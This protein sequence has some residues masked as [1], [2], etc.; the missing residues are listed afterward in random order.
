[1]MTK[2]QL[3]GMRKE[4]IP[5]VS[6]AVDAADLPVLAEWLTEKDDTV[7][8]HAFLLLQSRSAATADVYPFWDRFSDMLK[9]ANS[10]HR[11]IGLMLVAENAKWDELNKTDAVISDYL[12]LLHDEKPITVRQCIQSLGKIIPY[13]NQLLPV[14]ADKLMSLDL[15]KIRET[16]RKSVLTDIVAAL[17]EIQRIRP[18][19]KIGRYI[20]DALT[21]GLLDKKAAKMIESKLS[22]L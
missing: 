15:S 19:D 3:A 1:M 4:D 20:L 12:L 22:I 16:M 10:Y 2:E 5:A 11:S 17:A 18:A 7:R 6:A 9:S 14:I 21:G 8:Y 13:K